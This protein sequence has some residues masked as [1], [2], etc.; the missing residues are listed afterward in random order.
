MFIALAKPWPKLLI[1]SS[2]LLKLL[3]TGAGGGESRRVRMRFSGDGCG[4]S[5]MTI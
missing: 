3:L 5:S 1:F 4:L 2:L